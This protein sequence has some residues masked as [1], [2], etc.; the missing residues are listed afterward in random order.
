MDGTMALLKWCNHE[1]RVPARE[2]VPLKEARELLTDGDTD[3]DNVEII[4]EIIPTRQVGPVRKGIEIIP[5]LTSIQVERELRERPRLS[6]VLSDESDH[7][8]KYKVFTDSEGEMM[9]KE[10]EERKN[11]PEVFIEERPKRFRT[12]T[13]TMKTGEI[14]QGRVMHI[15]KTTPN[16]FFINDGM[17]KYRPID[18]TTV[19]EWLYED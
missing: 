12:V 18:M 1:R 13:L 3:I 19:Y 8:P 4:P 14:V 17:E 16:W 10:E 11:K 9:R 6:D 2:L 15:E 5:S 7:L